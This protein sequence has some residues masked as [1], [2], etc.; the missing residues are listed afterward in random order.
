MKI[1]KYFIVA[2]LAFSPVFLTANSNNQSYQSDLEGLWESNLCFKR[3]FSN[4]YR[5]QTEFRL[6]SKNSGK[7]TSEELWYRGSSCQGVAKHK[8]MKNYT[9]KIAGVNSDGS[10]KVDIDYG[11]TIYFGTFKIVGSSLYYALAGSNKDCSSSSQRCINIDLSS[12][13]HEVKVSS[14]E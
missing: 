7:V 13:N 12:N 5:T 1:M 6:T 3:P 8:R 9:F 10:I 14:F 4:S 2:A 11:H